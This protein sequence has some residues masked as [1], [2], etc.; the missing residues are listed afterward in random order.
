[1]IIK[2]RTI[3]NRLLN[4]S[5]TTN[6]LIKYLTGDNPLSTEALMDSLDDLENLRER[7]PEWGLPELIMPSFRE[8]MHKSLKSFSTIDY[9]LIH[10]FGEAGVCGIL[11][12]DHSDTVIYTFKNDKIK[13]WY[14][15][16]KNNVSTLCFYFEI[17]AFDDN[18]REIVIA[19]CLLNDDHIFAN[20]KEDRLSILQ[21]IAT[22]IVLYNAVKKYVKVEIVEIPQGKFTAVYGT[23][24]EYVEKKKVINQ[25]GQK[26]LV[27]DSKW[28][29]KIINNNEIFVRGFFRFQNKK[30]S[31]GVW[32][33]ELIFVESYVRNGYHRDATVE[34]NI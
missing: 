14:F 33:K 12:L 23:P 20:C 1:M 30:N 29:R 17:E 19:E 24:L 3:I 11:I 34:K 10:E 5:I 16:E 13:F 25:T 8:V 9:Q 15:N 7:N 32:Y 4:H 18:S 6:T 21:N 28:F 31:L 22:E 26:V 2:E 27:L